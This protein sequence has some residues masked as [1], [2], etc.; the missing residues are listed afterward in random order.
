MNTA[1]AIYEALLQAGVAD[2]PARRVV[3]ALEQDMTTLLATKQDLL[4]LEQLTTSKFESLAE[5]MNLQFQNQ[6]LRMQALESRI[7]IRLSVVTAALIA[8]GGALLALIR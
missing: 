1:L 3:A 7:V 8:T 5:R 6:D 2:A 4:H